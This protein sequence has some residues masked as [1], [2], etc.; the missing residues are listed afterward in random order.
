MTLIL[1]H[2][3]MQEQLL[4]ADRKPTDG[5]TGKLITNDAYKLVMFDNGAGGWQFAV[6]FTG[7][8][9]AGA[10]NTME[11]LVD[12]LPRYMSANVEFNAG[13]ADFKAASAKQF[14]SPRI[15][16]QLKQI[17]FVF[18][19]RYNDPRTQDWEPVTMLVS[20]TLN[21]DGTCSPGVLPA[22]NH[23]TI[24]RNLSVD[25][26]RVCD[27]RCFGDLNAV[28]AHGRSFARVQR[29]LRREIPP[30]TKFELA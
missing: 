14:W 21:S 28:Q 23:Q 4:V 12:A 25:P 26:N 30:S 22:F 1:A 7:L 3:T 24:R 2:F 27:T 8:A 15:K 9:S 17:T 5:L 10:F 29:Y 6:G 18:A 11:W 16:Q 20:N 13:L 19:G